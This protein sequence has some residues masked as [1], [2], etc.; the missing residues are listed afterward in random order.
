[1]QR[2][3]GIALGAVVTYLLLLLFD[4]GTRIVSDENTAYLVAVVLGAITSAFW[5]I[6][7][8]FWLGRRHRERQED[9]V[10]EEVARQ[11]AEQQKTTTPR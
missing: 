7:I 8:A 5:P 2:Y 3:I 11:L 6:V 9:K 4:G 10:Q 1:M